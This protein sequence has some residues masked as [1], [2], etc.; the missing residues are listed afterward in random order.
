MQP[1]EST[2]PVAE[3][4]A[5]YV[6]TGTTLTVVPVSYNK[7]IISLMNI[8]THTSVSFAVSAILMIIFR[9]IQLSV[10]CFLTGVLVDLDHI[11][12]YYMNH[13]LTAMLR[14]LYHPREFSR[15]LMAGHVQHEPAYRSYK[16]LHS[17]ELLIV[18]PILY[19]S[20]VWNAI[21]TGIVIGFVTHMVL[22]VLPLGYLGHAS[23]IWKIKNGFPTGSMIFR[24]RLSRI[25][26][27]MDVCQL[28][29]AHGDTL[30]HRERP[31]YIIFTKKSL[32][33]IM[34]LCPDC[35]D[36]IHGKKY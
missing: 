9:E 33:K 20:G 19:A 26:K 12:D 31:P 30:I 3:T 15:F 35:F 7:A 6:F 34:L 4:R 11:F 21:G 28:C 25:R 13:K 36:R 1:W 8:Y 5:C 14:L 18:A 16:P 32:N 23:L 24:N 2:D 27:D 17:I 10:A 22:D 29:N